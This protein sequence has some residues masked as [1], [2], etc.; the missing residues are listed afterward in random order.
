MRLFRTVVLFFIFTSAAFGEPLG[1]IVQGVDYD[2]ESRT[3]RVA[4]ESDTEPVYKDFELP[5]PD[6]VVL[7]LQDAAFP[8]NK[9]EATVGDGLVARLRAAQNSIDPAVTRVVVDLEAGVS[10]YTVGVTGGAPS[11][12]V[13]LTVIPAGSVVAVETEARLIEEQTLEPRALPGEEPPPTEA[14]VFAASPTPVRESPAGNARRVSEGLAGERVEA[15]AE[16]GGWRLV[17]LT[18]QDGLA[19]WVPSDSLVAEGKVERDDGSVR[20]VPNPRTPP[21]GTPQTPQPNRAPL[22]AEASDGSAIIAHLSADTAFRAYRRR[23]GWYFIKLED[24]RAGWVAARFVELETAGPGE[25]WRQAVV[26][27]AEGYIGSPY[28][29]GGTSSSG[30]DCSGLVWRVYKQNGMEIPRTAGPQY[31]EGRHISRGD[32][33]PGDLVFFSTYSAGPSHV[34]IYA[35]DDR[36]IQADSAD[37]VRYSDLDGVYWRDHIFGYSRWTP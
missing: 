23:E 10:G 4:V 5:D 18:E 9:F 26:S 15:V 8:A 1:A 35:G 16:L 14:L 24:G 11:W 25:A 34:G 30:F 33:L 32:L 12:S 19:G 27:T 3:V 20:A 7:D 29:W 31:R 17:I 28:V 36:F 21:P 37:G 6:R 22:R 2:P 13:N